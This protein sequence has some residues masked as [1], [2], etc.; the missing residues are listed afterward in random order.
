MQVKCFLAVV[1]AAC[2]LNA[3]V[4]AASPEPHPAA[5]ACSGCHPA[6]A[7]VQTPVPRL[8]GR[9]A[10]EIIE[11]MQAFRDGKREATVMGRIAKGFSDPEI[12]AIAVWY[13]QL[14]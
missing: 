14:N 8:Q 7:S 11:Q 13:A 9:N 5:M 10:T 4:F 6:T 12:Q 1:T 3:D 2:V